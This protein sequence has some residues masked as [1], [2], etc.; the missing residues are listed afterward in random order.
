MEKLQNKI[1]I[2]LQF[3]E[4]EKEYRHNRG[5]ELSCNNYRNHNACHRQT[6]DCS[7][8]S[9]TYAYDNSG[10]TMLFHSLRDMARH[11]VYVF[12]SLNQDFEDDEAGSQ[13]KVSHFRA[14]TVRSEPTLSVLF[15]PSRPQ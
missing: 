14:D 8:T 12:N 6:L 3:G 11:D 13:N 9:D 15:A 5:A 4:F 1:R 2:P 7:C 10:A